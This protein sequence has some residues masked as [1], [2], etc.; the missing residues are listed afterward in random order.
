MTNDEK[1]KQTAS[2]IV[3]GQNEQ[4][5]GLLSLLALL[6]TLYKK[7]DEL[8]D[9]L[10]HESRRADEVAYLKDAEIHKLE[11]QLG[12]VRAEWSKCKLE[13]EILKRKLDLA[14]GAI[15]N[16]ISFNPISKQEADFLKEVEE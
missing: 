10:Y 14:V 6:N 8:Q 4:S 12:F 16:V 5:D 9:K 11:T 1:D 7:I 2:D 13:S 3:V 15:K